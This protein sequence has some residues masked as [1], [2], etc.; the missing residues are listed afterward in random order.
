MIVSGV[1][2]EAQNLRIYFDNI[3]K[4]TRKLAA[5]ERLSL[6][7]TGSGPP[8][9]AAIDSVTELTMSLLNNKTVH[10]YETRFDCDDPQP[11][12]SNQTIIHNE[13]ISQEIEDIP[14]LIEGENEEIVV[15]GIDWSRAKAAHLK[16]PPSKKLKSQEQKEWTKRRRPLTV[17]SELNDSYKELIEEKKFFF[18]LQNE[19]LQRKK[20]TD[21]EEFKLRREILILD[22]ELKRKQ[23][24]MFD[25]N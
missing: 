15:E 8:D 23:L 19:M 4:Q 17:R 25:D 16:T 22:I 12:T 7:K 14:V 21:D 6:K 11:G 13:D 18:Q 9:C 24:Q 1:Y 5:D 10:G 3:K 20:I 2:R